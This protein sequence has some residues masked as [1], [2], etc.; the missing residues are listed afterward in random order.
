MRPL[1]RRRK[2][3]RAWRRILLLAA[4]VALLGTAVYAGQQEDYRVRATARDGILVY[5]ARPQE[6][7]PP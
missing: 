3:R 4:V 5:S 6:D 1:L 2:R 7:V